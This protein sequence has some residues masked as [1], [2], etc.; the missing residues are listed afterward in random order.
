[1]STPILSELSTLSQP[2]STNSTQNPDSTELV[3]NEPI[4]EPQESQS[5]EKPLQGKWGIF[6][7]TFF[8]IFLAEIGDKTQ[9]ATL[10]ISAQSHSPWIVFTGAAMALIT[11]SLL[12]VLIGHWLSKRVSPKTMETAAGVLLLF[13]AVMLLLDVAHLE[14]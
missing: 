12:G 2:D 1:M 9:L 8:T 5:L 7:S 4:T 14:G 3:T 13:I 11:T 10:L 6:C